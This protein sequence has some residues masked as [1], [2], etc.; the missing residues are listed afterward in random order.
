MSSHT[1]SDTSSA[2]GEVVGRKTVSDEDANSGKAGAKL[3]K[4]DAEEEEEADKNSQH[5]SSTAKT[6]QL[7]LH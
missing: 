6:Q 3:S 4:G 1:N 2:H 5:S 7:S